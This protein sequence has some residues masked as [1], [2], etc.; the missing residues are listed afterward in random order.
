MERKYKMEK[1]KMKLRKKKKAFGVVGV[2]KELW[3][4]ETFAFLLSQ[5][6]QRALCDTKFYPLV[7]ILYHDCIYPELNITFATEQ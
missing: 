2:C 5:H 6:R 3:H 1:V 7:T 4:K